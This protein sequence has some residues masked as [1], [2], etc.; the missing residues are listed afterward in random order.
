MRIKIALI[1]FIVA[2][3]IGSATY[4][5]MAVTTTQYIH[6][7]IEDINEAIVNIPER[8]PAGPE[9]RTLAGE[10]LTTGAVPKDFAINREIYNDTLKIQEMMI[11]LMRLVLLLEA[12]PF[13]LEKVKKQMGAIIYLVAFLGVRYNFIQ[14]FSILIKQLQE[15]MAEIEQSPPQIFVIE[16]PDYGYM[17]FKARLEVILAEIENKLR[18]KLIL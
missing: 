16:H 1:F 9:V 8:V 11:E 13:L 10:Q 5:L 15:I 12:K 18:T 17:L 2:G 4:L 7:T 3:Y 14:Q 6:E